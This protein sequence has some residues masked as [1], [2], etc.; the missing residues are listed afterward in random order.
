MCH[1][2]R[3]S[4]D[5]ISVTSISKD[6]PVVVKHVAEVSKKVGAKVNMVQSAEEVT[7]PEVKKAIE[8]GKKVTGWY[9]EKTG[10]VHL[11]MSNIHD[12]YTAPLNIYDAIEE[13]IVSS[14]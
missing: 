13:G 9:D 12:R 11:Y 14:F 10:E 1:Q 3:I 2:P 5:P 4:A 6:A 7:N 8:S